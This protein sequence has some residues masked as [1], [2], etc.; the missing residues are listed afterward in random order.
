MKKFGSIL[1]GLLFV[2]LT[3]S[4][5]VYV[6][7][8]TP[9]TI[10]Y[11]LVKQLYFVNGSLTSSPTCEHYLDYG[12]CVLIDDYYNDSGGAVIDHRFNVQATS[13]IPVNTFTATA[14]K[15]EKVGGIPLGQVGVNDVIA[16]SLDQAAQAI[17]KLLD[18]NNQVNNATNTI[19]IVK[20]A[21][22][23]TV[24]A[25][26]SE[27]ALNLGALA[28]QI[29]AG[30][31]FDV[32]VSIGGD[33]PICLTFMIYKIGV[34]EISFTGNTQLRSDDN[35]TAYSAPHYR[36]SNVNGNTTDEYERNWPTAFTANSVPKLTA[37]LKFNVNLS[38]E[39]IKIKSD[40]PITV[41]ETTATLSSNGTIATITNANIGQMP[42][43]VKFY[44]GDFDIAWQVK[45]GDNPWTEVQTTHH[46][47]Y[48]SRFAPV[49]GSGRQESLFYI[50][51]KYADGKTTASEIIGSV[52]SHIETLN[53]TRVGN[54][55]PLKYWGN[56]TL[57][58]GNPPDVCTHYQYLLA[59]G[60]GTCG[61]WAEFFVMLLRA[62]GIDTA[63]RIRVTPKP[64]EHSQLGEL[65][66]RNLL[67]REWQ[68]SPTWT[69]LTRLPAQG[70]N[71]SPDSF[72]DHAVVKVGSIVYDPAYGLKSNSDAAHEDAAFAGIGFRQSNG[73]PVTFVNPS[74]IMLTQYIEIPLP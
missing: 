35:G 12:Q 18:S 65:S 67:V 54:S 29:A 59:N 7:N 11:V 15:L 24:L 21:G 51:T 64:F 32:C 70:N 23:N 62:Q 5:S 37:K 1:L 3:A 36:D 6:C 19:W 44:D 55:T 61:A 10:K 63:K 17:I 22:S 20:S 25:T 47:A 60:D 52:W 16:L 74:T 27:A 71:S 40:G 43:S 41:Q 49:S 4:G 72:S 26:V 45:I 28:A 73:N 42:N 13:V 58:D 14:V 38:G 53:V 50:S 66:A 2:C 31:A 69:P 34:Q 30:G 56:I 57:V 8:N 33:D 48:F 39:Q 9:G 46:R 68:S